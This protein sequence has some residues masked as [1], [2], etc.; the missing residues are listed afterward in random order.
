MN[1]IDRVCVSWAHLLAGEG[2]SKYK[3]ADKLTITVVGMSLTVE[4]CRGCGEKKG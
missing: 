1:K 2:D 3:E 4:V